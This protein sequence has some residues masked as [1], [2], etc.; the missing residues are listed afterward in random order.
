MKEES[1]LS[2]KSI[3]AVDDEPDVLSLL[4]EEIQ[5]VCT[6]CVFDRA[7]T[8]EEASQKMIS[9]TYDLVILD[10]M[11][12]RG[13]ELLA[14]AVSRNFKVA[15][16]TAHALTPEALKRSFEMKAMAYLPKEKLGEIVPFLE[17]ALTYGYLPGWKKLLIKLGDF[18]AS[19]W[20]GKWKK[21]EERLWK[22]FAKVQ[23]PSGGRVGSL[24]VTSPHTLAAPPLGEIG[25]GR[26]LE[27]EAVRKRWEPAMKIRVLGCSGADFPGN[28]LPGFL[29][30]QE[31]LFDAGSLTTVLDEKEQR[32]VQHIF[33]THAHLDHIIGI[34]FL[35]DNIIA[36]K[37]GHRVNIYAIPSV[38]KTIKRHLFNSSVWPDFTEIPNVEYGVL[39]LIELKTG[40]PTQVGEYAIT[41]YRVNH[42]VSA[43]G[44]LVENHPK[45]R[46]FYTGDMGPSKE[47]W[48]KLKGIPIDC[49]VI[50]VSFPSFMTDM[51]LRTGHLTPTLLKEELLNISPAP[52]RVL[53]THTKTQYYQAIK[54]EIETLH[55]DGI[56]I[57]KDGETL[58]I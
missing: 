26:Q 12:V 13:F 56:R 14:K 5:G 20:G 44:Y 30:D 58:R 2:G 1:I 7:T 31:I 3:L 9:H 15:M 39:N 36:G 48:K 37:R 22:E 4:E 28:H 52:K 40:Q 33:I 11:G 38:V 19:H 18:F 17:G 27:R 32:K 34:P 35:A 10:I 16:L 54:K 45:K 51:A 43:V 47:T 46:I 49:L 8:F 42:T 41:A 53:A 25:A 24:T 29:L 50:D 23:P 6:D 57:L 21:R 55:M